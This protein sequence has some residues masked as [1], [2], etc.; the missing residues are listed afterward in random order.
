LTTAPIVPVPE[1][2]LFD[3]PIRFGIGEWGF[4]LNL[5]TGKFVVYRTK[6]PDLAHLTIMWGTRSGDLDVH[7][8]YRH[9]GAMADSKPKDYVPLFTMSKASL[10]AAG[11]AYSENAER[12]M[13]PYLRRAYRKFRPGWLAHRNYYV[14]VLGNEIMM[15]WLRDLAP[16]RRR[17]YRFDPRRLDPEHYPPEML[18]SVYDPRILH[19]L[20]GDE[21]KVP[22]S[23]T[24][25]RRGHIVK[26]DGIQLFFM[27]GPNGTKGWWGMKQRDLHAMMREQVRYA[28]DKLVPLVQPEH[29][30]IW[31]QIVAGLGMEDFKESRSFAHTVRQFLT[32]PRNPVG[33]P[34]PDP[35]PRV[36]TTDARVVPE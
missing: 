34:Y 30:D 12:I 15:K 27:A 26:D 13:I 35:P 2:G 21:L 11:M 28:F 8:A 3:Q 22:V 4:I 14:T 25:V 7:L 10:E 1:T 36:V 17:K 31:E 19:Y 33:R 6:R 32:D 20:E 16:K 24:R 29:A 5:N 9:E 18:E 23:A